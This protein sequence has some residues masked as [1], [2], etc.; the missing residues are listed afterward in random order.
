MN[1]D[2]EIKQQLT[3]QLTIAHVGMD[4][5][6]DELQKYDDNDIVMNA[7]EAVLERFNTMSDLLAGYDYLSTYVDSFVISNMVKTL[8]E[9]NSNE[10]SMINDSV[11]CIIQKRQPRMEIPEF[12]T[13][14]GNTFKSFVTNDNK[15][16]IFARLLRGVGK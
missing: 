5:L 12:I 15:Y 3:H 4:E 8:K 16:I 2:Q 13:K 11:E 9:S 7:Y 10:I 14:D 1:N 6:K